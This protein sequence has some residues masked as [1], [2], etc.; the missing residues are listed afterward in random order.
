MKY[1]ER[2]CTLGL[3]CRMFQV[4]EGLQNQNIWQV[5]Y[6]TVG[7]TTSTLHW[8]RGDMMFCVRALSIPRAMRES[9]CVSCTCRFCLGLLKLQHIYFL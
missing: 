8:E 3:N 1:S 9:V 4:V 5:F 2:F 7:P 6:F